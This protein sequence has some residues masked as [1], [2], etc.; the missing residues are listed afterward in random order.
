[1]CYMVCSKEGWHHGFIPGR[2]VDEDSLKLKLCL[3]CKHISEN[4]CVCKF[5]LEFMYGQMQITCNLVFTGFL[6]IPNTATHICRKQQSV[7]KYRSIVPVEIQGVI[8]LCLSVMLLCL[9]TLMSPVA[10]NII[11]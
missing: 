11:Y 1:M 8:I 6:A 10:D 3:A 9:W 5:K 4:K 2:G 7:A